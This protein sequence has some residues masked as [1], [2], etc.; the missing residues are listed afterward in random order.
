MNMTFPD[1]EMPS[2]SG[3]LAPSSGTVTGATYKYMLE[4]GKY[5]LSTLD[6]SSKERI[7]V[8]APSKLIVNGDVDI[9]GAI[10]I[11]PGGALELYVV[12]EKTSLGGTGVNNTGYASNFVYYG[13]PSNTKITVPSNGD[14][15]GVFYAPSASLTLSGGGSTELHFSGACIVNRIDINGHYKFHF[16]E[17]LIKHGPWKDYVIYS[18][19]EL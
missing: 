14:F 15:T 8:T 4:G 5:V 7:A 6:V 19:I 1:V 13:L 2:L 12:G 3:S 9:R 10:D 11:M 16:D 17:A 18:W